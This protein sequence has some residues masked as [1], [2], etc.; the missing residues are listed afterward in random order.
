MRGTRR[1]PR[2]NSALITI[3]TILGLGL[4]WEGA[5]RLLEIPRF[6]LPAPSGIAVK[7]V[8]MIPTLLHHAGATLSHAAVG[9]VIGVTSGILLA[10][11]MTLSPGVRSAVYPLVIASQTVPKIA[12]A[13][14]LVIW[15]GVGMVSKVLMVALLAF[16]P[17]LINSL[18]GLST[19]TRDQLDL[20]KS[21]DASKFEEYRRL[22]IPNAIP[23]IF[24]GLKL[25]LTVSIIGAIVSEWVAATAGLGHLLVL[26]NATL[27]TTEV[28]VVLTALIVIASSAFAVIM[29]A[30]R[31]FSWQARLHTQR[32]TVATSAEGSM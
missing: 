29:L 5:V 1:R 25:G 7:L 18:T 22:R 20:M 19:V 8:E 14:L 10:V 23:W 2:A 27:R 16:F 24:A 28:F 21:V 26:Y 31:L 15:F 30:E 32:S 17:V 6:V 12:I 11:L 3:G 9:Y 4:L 13:P